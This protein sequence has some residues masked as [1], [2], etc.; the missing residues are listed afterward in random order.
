M[1]KKTKKE[2]QEWWN[3]LTPIEQEEYIKKKQTQKAEERQ[4][5]PV[6]IKQSPEINASNK[7]E[8]LKKIVK[9]NPWLPERSEII[10]DM[11]S[12]KED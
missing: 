9:K 10:R 4:K 3:N 11:M 7:K 1:Y 6:K 12:Q 5:H 8:W 2:K